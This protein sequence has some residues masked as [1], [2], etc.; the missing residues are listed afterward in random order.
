[1]RRLVLEAVTGTG[2]VFSIMACVVVSAVPTE[3]PDCLL[4]V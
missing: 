1:G 4:S 2:A 3:I